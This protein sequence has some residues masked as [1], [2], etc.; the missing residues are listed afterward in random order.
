MASPG[1]ARS[2]DGPGGISLARP[3]R[4]WPP[5]TQPAAP[6]IPPDGLAESGWNY[7]INRAVP[8]DGVPWE[9]IATPAGKDAAN[10]SRGQAGAVPAF[11][12]EARP[13]A[14]VPVETTTRLLGNAVVMPDALWKSWMARDLQDVVGIHFHEVVSTDEASIL[15]TIHKIPPDPPPGQ[16]P[17]EPQRG[18][19]GARIEATLLRPVAMHLDQAIAVRDDPLNKSLAA[20]RAAH[21]AGHAEVSRQV[22]FAVIAGPQDWN[23]QYCTGRR[24]RIEYYWQQARIGRTWEGY[25]HSEGK[26]LT[27]RLSVVLVPPTRWSMML[28]VPPERVTQRQVQAFNDAI[29]HMSQ[30]FAVV[31]R[32]AQGRFHAEHGEFEP[33]PEP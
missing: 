5:A 9:L 19:S 21:E 32:A 15:F 10:W 25:R 30:T 33:P 2:E 4:L 22:L 8:R 14:D 29:V 12:R 18:P 28:P 16:R 6:D 24:S 13:M 27:T 20:A 31:D 3:V 7:R 1:T 23:V 11:A 17:P 26:L